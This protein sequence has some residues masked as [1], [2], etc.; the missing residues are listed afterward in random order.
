M[1]NERAVCPLHVNDRRAGEHKT[2]SSGH[3]GPIP[4]SP[5]VEVERRNRHPS[6]GHAERLL[7]RI[8]NGLRGSSG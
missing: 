4:C 8:R 5:D 7:R 1:C 3:A 6:R 2:A